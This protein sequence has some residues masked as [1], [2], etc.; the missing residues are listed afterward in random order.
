MR[1]YEYATKAMKLGDGKQ[2][3]RRDRREWN[4][5]DSI[6]TTN[7]SV[8]YNYSQGPTTTTQLLDL[9]VVQSGTLTDI[10]IQ[11]HLG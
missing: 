10:S 7:F 11:I 5:A 4:D 8:R 1:I 9:L 2:E 3:R 6:N